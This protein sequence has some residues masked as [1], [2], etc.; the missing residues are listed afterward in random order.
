MHRDSARFG[1]C[2][3]HLGG[4]TSAV[5]GVG[6]VLSVA[7]PSEPEVAF[8][9][10]RR[11][12]GSKRCFDRRASEPLRPRTMVQRC[13]GRWVTTACGTETTLKCFM[14]LRVWRVACCG[15]SDLPLLSVPIECPVCDCKVGAFPATR[16][17]GRTVSCETRPDRREGGN[18]VMASVSVRSV[19]SA[20]RAWTTRSRQR[21]WCIRISRSTHDAS[22][23]FLRRR[24]FIANT[25]LFCQV[26]VSQWQR[27]DN[28]GKSTSEGERSWTDGADVA[29]LC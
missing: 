15:S 20:Q 8:C 21:A 27:R 18:I 9:C 4:V 13:Y 26:I 3:G 29:G 5:Q 28:S 17:R 16:R 25:F 22:G 11:S 24:S 2:V 10:R 1:G 14:A 6:L 23:D 7:T 12:L 19:Q